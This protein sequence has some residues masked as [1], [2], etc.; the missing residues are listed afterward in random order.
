MEGAVGTG[1]GVLS[2]HGAYWLGL[3]APQSSSCQGGASGCL[4]ATSV[5]LLG[6]QQPAARAGCTGHHIELRS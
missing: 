5:T 2:Q 6:P 3:G 4:D 1:C